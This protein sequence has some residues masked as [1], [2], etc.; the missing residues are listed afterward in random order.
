MYKIVFL[1]LDDTLLDNEKNI[2]QENKDAIKYVQE[3][4]GLV[5][6]A[7]GRSIEATKKYCKMAMASR[8]I[9]YSNGAG[10][11]DCEANEKLFSADIEKELCVQLYN[12]GIKSNLGIRIDTPY[13]RYISNEKYALN[14]DIV[15]NPEEG[16]K[17]IAE[18][19]ILQISF[20]SVEEEKRNQAIEFFNSQIPKTL[21]IENIFKT[22]Y[23][24]EF[25]AINLVNSNVSKGNAIN[26]LCKFLKINIEEVIAI[27]DGLNDISMIKTAGLGVAMKNATEEVKKVA[28]EITSTNMGNG[29]A[30]IL[31]EKF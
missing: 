28:D 10:I 27:G 26:G 7:S 23:E 5:C 20:L 12:Y 14:L 3:K 2:S 6:I 22:G 13:G 18:N 1:D 31:R 9:I 29:V 16:E 30:K 4:G 25:F 21:K 19:D 24:N 15:F 17:I 11:F 8:Y